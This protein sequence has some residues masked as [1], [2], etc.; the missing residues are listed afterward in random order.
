[1]PHHTRPGPVQDQGEEMIDLDG[2]DLG[3]GSGQDEER[4]D[5]ER[6]TAIIQPLPP[7]ADIPALRKALSLAQRALTE[8]D[9]ELRRVKKELFALTAAL[10]PK[11]RKGILNKSDSLNKSIG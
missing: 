9:A 8:T 4:R 5:Q 3:D 10:P 6:I 11:K 1:M 7:D 2:S